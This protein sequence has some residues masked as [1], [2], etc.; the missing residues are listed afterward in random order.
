MVIGDGD[1][2]KTVINYNL[3]RDDVIFFASGVSNS[4][5]TKDENFR[6][7]V[8]KLHRLPADSHVIYFS[9]LCVYYSDSIYADHKRAMEHR[10]KAEFKSNTIIRLGNIT[11]GNNPNTII[12]YFKAEHTAGRTPELHNTFRFIITKPE[13]IYWMNSIRTGVN[14]IM[15]IPGEMVTI[16]EI[17]RRVVDGKY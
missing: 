9:S 5:E 10:I 12:N 11:W 4:K 14:D 15:N 7:E 6:R 2:A 17:W 16:K 13:F 8:N 1:I 3:D